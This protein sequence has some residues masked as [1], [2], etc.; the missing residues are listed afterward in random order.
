MQLQIKHI[1]T[2]PGNMPLFMVVCDGK[3][4]QPITLVSPLEIPVGP[5]NITLQQAIRWYMEK[6]MEL[7]TD[8]FCIRAMEV[9]EALSSWGRNCFNTL[10]VGEQEQNW[11]NDAKQNG[12]SNLHIEIVSNSPAVLS[13]PWEALKNSDGEF[14]AQHCHI[15]RQL[16]NINKPHSSLEYKM[17]SGKINILYIIPRPVID[18]LEYQT[19]ARPLINFINEGN[20]PVHID[21]LRPPTFDKLC[22][23]LKEKPDFY[24]IIHFDGHGDYDAK[25]GGILVFEKDDLD[26]SDK[27]VSAYTFGEL[28]HNHN[29]PLIV[30]NACRSAM[31]D[32]DAETA[33]ASV[34]T[35]LL[36]A[37]VPNVVAMSYSLWVSGAKAFV[38]AFYQKIFQTGDVV[39]AM[40]AGRKA[41]Y[42]SKNR[43]TSHGPIEFHDWIV[44]VLYQQTAQQSILPKLVPNKTENNKLSKEMP[45]MGKHGLI[46]YDK[47][48]LQ[49]E[50][51]I[52]EKPVGIIIHG[53][54]G[55]G[56]TTLVQGFL[57]WLKNTNGID[58]NVFW[59]N[60]KDKQSV[61]T[62][63]DTL[64]TE[65]K[66]VD[67]TKKLKDK[68]CFI[69][70]DS[71]ET[72][73]RKVDPEVSVQFR[74]KERMML[75]HFLHSLYG[76]KTKIFIT[77]CSSENWLTHPQEDYPVY[78]CCRIP[79][80]GFEGE[81]LW[82]YCSVIVKNLFSYVNSGGKIYKELVNRL[83]NGNPL[84][85]QAILPRLQERT[86]G[87]LITELNFSFNG[88][89][90]NEATQRIQAT[91]SEFEKQITPT[92][93]P[94]LR[95]IS[96]HEQQVS[97]N[98][99]ECMLKL[100]DVN[101]SPVVE[102]IATL[103]NMGLCRF[104]ADGIYQMH[105]ALRSYLTQFY[106]AQEID[107]RIFVEAM[108]HLTTIFEHN[109]L[110]MQRCFFSNIG[111]SF[112]QALKLSKEL[113][114]RET[115]SLTF[116]LATYSFRIRNFSEAE[117]LY[118][119]HIAVA[120]KYNFSQLEANAYC[121]LGIIAYELQK[122]ETADDRYKQ[123][124]Y[125]FLELGDNDSIA[126]TYHELGMVAT[127]LEKFD[128]AK[129]WHKKALDINL[130]MD[131]K[132]SAAITYHELGNATM[133]Q[134]QVTMKQSELYAAK[135]WYEKAL[136]IKREID[137]TSSSTAATCHQLGMVEYEL[138]NLDNAEVH[139]KEAQ[140]IELSLHNE[141]EEA[142]A[143][144][145]LGRIEEKRKKFDTAE[146]YYKR[147]LAIFIRLKDVHTAN[148]VK[149][150]IALLIR[151]K[152]ST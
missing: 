132:A 92:F 101:N 74:E 44:P 133:K 38:P 113:D 27:P 16:F 12:L 51:A 83:L 48:F 18:Y 150:N 80:I 24:H 21:V 32:K 134:G 91:F 30:L 131:N 118:T 88:L 1:D 152:D 66:L 72:V 114:M 35:S 43:D 100:M 84:A 23:V 107:K 20:W 31:Q 34:A 102:C 136:A 121:R 142:K 106:P 126:K 138:G 78:E 77:S 67:L 4:S 56:K 13:W 143:L 63:L 17:S 53:L 124:L 115:L 120:K 127:A 151:K 97:K 99:L 69:V 95:L 117:R 9:Q 46:G 79:L 116:A 112:Y 62:M 65:Q 110:L 5:R 39:N 2:S 45:A 140:S 55:E 71:F 64:Q 103:E 85:I 87:A 128:D 96:L 146:E 47:I 141:H 104:I 130:K 10:F 98:I 42:E 86:A 125:I 135:D 11:Y 94:I 119:E 3:P 147:A 40:F 28:L 76:S 49:L 22:A 26:H 82:Q 54:M 25:L 139:Y 60:F 122:F 144:H 37:G 58:G 109:D 105:P 123:A 19:L 14:L 148:I 129:N 149:H 70:W 137:N 7:P 68:Q 93:I 29:I 73:S 50:R 33:F 145:E 59:F 6:Y 75:K 90:G 108:A 15:K 89:E 52:R 61:E 41:M 57:Q 81:E 111:L 8:I 36:Q